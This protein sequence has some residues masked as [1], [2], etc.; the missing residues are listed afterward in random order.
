[1]TGRP[2]MSRISDRALLRLVKDRVSIHSTG[3]VRGAQRHHF[4]RGEGSHHH[5]AGDGRARGGEHARRFFQRLV[6]PAGRARRGVQREHLV[7]DVG[8]EHLTRRPTIGAVW[9]GLWVGDRHLVA[10]VLASSAATKRKPE[11]TNTRVVGIGDAAAVGLAVAPGL[12]IA[13]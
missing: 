2:G 13:G 10:P 11:V 1:M 5:V 9:T 3:A 8:E 6:V 4:A 7:L 12:G